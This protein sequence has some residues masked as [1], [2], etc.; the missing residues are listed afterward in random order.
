VT[1]EDDIF[2]G[3]M[4]LFITAFVVVILISACGQNKRVESCR[5]RGGYPITERGLYRDCVV[6]IKSIDESADK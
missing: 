6:G 3:G 2:V 1:R 4:L 5:E